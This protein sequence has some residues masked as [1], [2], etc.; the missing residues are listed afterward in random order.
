MPAERAIRV[1]F[2]AR[3]KC[4]FPVDYLPH[5]VGLGA[6][7]VRDGV[8]ELVRVEVLARTILAEEAYV[9]TELLYRVTRRRGRLPQRQAK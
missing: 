2:L 9:L 5:Q 1:E 4:Q 7:R 8:R 3:M 6:V